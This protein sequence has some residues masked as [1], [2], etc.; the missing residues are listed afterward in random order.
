MP[1]I[2]GT[3]AGAAILRSYVGAQEIVR[4]YAGAVILADFTTLTPPTNITASA[5][6]DETAPGWSVEYFWANTDFNNGA[7]TINW[8]PPVSTGGRAITGYVVQL[9]ATTFNAAPNARTHTFTNVA[10]TREECVAFSPSVAAVTAAGVGPA[11][12]VATVLPTDTVPVLNLIGAEPMYGYADTYIWAIEW[13]PICVGN[14]LLGVDDGLPAT[15]APF[16]HYQVQQRVLGGVWTHVTAAPLN[17]PY[18]T[19]TGLSAT[20]TAVSVVARQFRVRTARLVNNVVVYGR[21]SNIV[22]G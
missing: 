11:V 4:I 7:I 8:Q 9:G 19:T 13:T 18:V 1:G 2:N 15:S 6:I 20:L 14:G 21:W 5:A 22:E 16:T 3:R 10:W 12:S 17:N